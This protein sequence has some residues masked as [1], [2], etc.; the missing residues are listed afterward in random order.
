VNTS[1][2][3]ITYIHSNPIDI[4]RGYCCRKVF[5]DKVSIRCQLVMSFSVALFMCFA[6]ALIICNVAV[7]ILG[8][9][10]Y[11]ISKREIRVVTNENALLNARSLSATIRSHHTRCSECKDIYYIHMCRYAYNVLIP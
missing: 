8:E 6:L 1:H 4:M 7:Y 9:Y 11:D 10:A 2:S 5:N 3:Y